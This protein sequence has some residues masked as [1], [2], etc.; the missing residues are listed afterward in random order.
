MQRLRGRLSADRIALLD[1]AGF[2]WDARIAT[3][4]D[5]FANLCDFK[6][7]FRHTRVPVKWK[8]NPDLGHWVVS[9]RYKK[10]KGRLRPEY[11]HRLSDIG[12]EWEVPRAIPGP[13]VW[14]SK[15]KAFLEY[16]AATGRSDFSRDDPANRALAA[17]VQ[18]QRGLKRRG[19]LAPDRERQLNEIGFPWDSKAPGGEAHWRDR[20]AE[21]K[22]Y[23]AAHGTTRV[24]A[25][26]QKS[27]SLKEWVS[28]Q[29][30]L[31]KQGRLPEDRFRELEAIGFMWNARQG[32]TSLDSALREDDKGKRWEEMRD[33]LFA[34]F[35]LHGHCNVPDQWPAN[36]RLAD[37]VKSIR[38]AK[39]D[40]KLT[41]EQILSVEQLGFAWTAVDARWATMLGQLAEVLRHNTAGPKAG[42]DLSAWVAAVRRLKKRSLL[43]EE[44]ERELSAIGFKWKPGD[45][46]WDQMLKR[47]EDYRVQNGDCFVPWQWTEDRQLAT[48]VRT[49]RFFRAAGRLSDE[50]IKALDKLGFQWD[51]ARTKNRSPNETWE[52]MF[53]RLEG[54]VKE[55]GHAHVPQNFAVDRKLGR[56]VSTQRQHHRKGRLDRERFERLQSVGFTWRVSGGYRAKG[57]PVPI[58]EERWRRMLEA[59][60][61]FRDDRGHCRVPAGWAANPQLANWVGVQRRMRKL[62]RL[63]VDRIAA[64]D[65][66]GFSWNPSPPI[67]APTFGVTDC[68]PDMLRQLAEFKKQFGHCRVPQRWTTNRRLADWVSDQRSLRNRGRISADH[69]RALA[70]LGFDWDPTTTKWEAMFL[71]LKAFKAK[72]GHV[73]VPGNSREHVRLANWVKNQRRDRKLGRPITVE[74]ARR[75]DE[76]GFVWTFV[77]PTNWEEMFAELVAFKREHG[78][79]NVPQRWPQNLKLGRWVNTQRWRSSR[80]T[81]KRKQMLTELGFVW[82]TQAVE[83]SQNNASEGPLASGAIEDAANTG[84]SLVANQRSG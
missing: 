6:T 63:S 38:R 25:V 42:S 72:Y 11:A 73:N 44:Q 78:H 70:D 8:E 40:G 56:W 36:P 41:G 53:A 50:R 77:T 83:P 59:L 57:Q 34:F 82:N 13:D 10:R 2:S 31:R 9:Q 26:D 16:R 12:F 35:K 14:V 62:G 52:V 65:E 39:R 55:S 80:L 20:L 64:L 4:E 27:R 47:L 1:R 66:L 68:W 81:A 69:E 5:R 45:E 23:S 75:L 7:R 84:Q 19:K 46:R 58:F 30:S 43:S 17:W 24:I 28:H 15:F 32:R 33:A 74:R 61:K 54:F 79:C 76:L 18:D 22:A 71:E 21:L 49:Q 37:W 48:W 67:L 29:R 3:W 51:V 60:R